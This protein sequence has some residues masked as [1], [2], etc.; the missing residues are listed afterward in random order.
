M[1]LLVL[2]ADD[3]LKASTDPLVSGVRRADGTRVTEH[4]EPTDH[5]WSDKRVALE[6]AVIDWLATLR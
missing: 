6:T 4:H 1:P 5:G 3:G 2:T